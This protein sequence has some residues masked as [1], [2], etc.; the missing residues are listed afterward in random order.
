MI[1][2]YNKILNKFK[3]LLKETL[4]QFND[5]QILKKEF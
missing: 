4:D 1:K 2:D 3:N 5:A